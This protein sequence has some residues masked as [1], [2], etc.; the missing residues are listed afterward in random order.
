[1][2]VGCSWY[3][4]RGVFSLR[5][6]AGCW[7]ILHI[8]SQWSSCFLAA[9]TIDAHALLMMVN[10]GQ[11]F[12]S[13]K[14]LR[15]CCLYTSCVCTSWECFPFICLQIHEQG[16][17]AISTNTIIST[18]FGKSDSSLNSLNDNTIP[19]RINVQN[20]FV[21]ANLKLKMKIFF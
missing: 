1:V 9:S 5:I 10:T 18:V 3:R 6:T 2:S 7:G 11:W 15:Y 16:K 14:W 17:S 20:Q 4:K 8:P 12:G 19:T 21:N 13:Y